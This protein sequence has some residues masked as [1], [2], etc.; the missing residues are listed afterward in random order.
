MEWGCKS[1]ICGSFFSLCCKIRLGRISIQGER[2]ILS[3]ESMGGLFTLL[4]R[5]FGYQMIA[6]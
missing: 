4:I 6:L 2:P 3:S 5:G 1:K